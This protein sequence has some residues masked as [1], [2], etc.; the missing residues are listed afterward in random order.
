MNVPELAQ[1]FNS[2][3]AQA[4]VASES[5]LENVRSQLQG[6]PTQI[7]AGNFAAAR[8]LLEDAAGQ[9]ADLKFPPDSAPEINAPDFYEWEARIDYAEQKWNV[10]L[11]LFTLGQ[12]FSRVLL[13]EVAIQ[14]DLPE[15]VVKDLVL[16]LISDGSIPARF[17]ENTNG[18]EL[19]VEMEELDALRKQFDE[20]QD[21]KKQ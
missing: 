10:H 4:K 14:T 20:W 16:E 11:A 8:G 5:V 18:I 9:F 1:K 6:I 2:L 19:M 15:D 21:G 13:Q 3:E 17:D 7:D 12:Q